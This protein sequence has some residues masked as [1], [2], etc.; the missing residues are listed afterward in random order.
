MLRPPRWVGRT[1]RPAP[2]DRRHSIAPGTSA[3]V[4]LR[5]DRLLP[6][7]P[8]DRYILRD[9]GRNETLGGGEVLDLAP[10]LPLS[11]A[12]PD[13]RWERVVAERG[14]VAVEELERLTG[15]TH[16]PTIGR[17]VVRPDAVDTMAENLRQRVAG[18]AMPGL[19]IGLLDEHEQACSNISTTSKSRRSG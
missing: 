4:W 15:K 17:W 8:G 2:S 11:K 1:Q 9:W 7:Q 16:T 3:A 10:V 6:L 19:A 5:N 12:V 13:T 18:A 14:W